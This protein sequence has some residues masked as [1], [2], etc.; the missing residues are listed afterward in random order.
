MHRGAGIVGQSKQP[1]SVAQQNLA[2]GCQMQPFALA[3]KQRR[4]EIILELPDPRRHVGLHT[5]QPL[6][7][8]GYP[9]LADDSTKDA[10]P[11]QIHI[12]LYKM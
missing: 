8:A 4:P 3:N 10:Q 6:G 11:G 12:S 9:A 2:G 1:V 7:G 5:M